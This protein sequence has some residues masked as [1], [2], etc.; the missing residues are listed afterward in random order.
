MLCS[1]WPVCHAL[2][3]WNGEPLHTRA[4]FFRVTTHRAGPPFTFQCHCCFCLQVAKQNWEL[5]SLIQAEVQRL[6]EASGGA[7]TAASTG[8]LRLL[9]QQVLQH[10]GQ[11]SATLF[12]CLPV[13]AGGCTLQL[14]LPQ[15]ALQHAVQLLACLLPRLPAGAGKLHSVH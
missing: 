11:C 5:S 12:P 3:I 6:Q 4:V 9:L 1:D 13:G 8:R 7:G 15:Q 2:S 14:L 10:A